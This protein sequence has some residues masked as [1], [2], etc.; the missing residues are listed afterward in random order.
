LTLAA[1]V[2][3]EPT[4]TVFNEGIQSAAPKSTQNLA[5]VEKSNRVLGSDLGVD[6][7]EAQRIVKV[8]TPWADESRKVLAVA[9]KEDVLRELGAFVQMLAASDK[10]LKQMKTS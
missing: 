6:V 3:A 9:P 1:K 5:W 7:D 10:M 4:S 2:K 8:M